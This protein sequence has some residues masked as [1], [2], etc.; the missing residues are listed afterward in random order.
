[1]KV[2]KTE[3][4]SDF[5]DKEKRREYYSKIKEP[6]SSLSEVD[7]YRLRIV[8]KYLIGKSVL[9]IGTYR[10]D[11]LKM[12]S[13]KFEITGLDFNNECVNIV[14]DYF[15]KKVAYVGNLEI[16]DHLIFKDN[17]FD[18]VTCLEVIEHLP[19]IG[20]VINE[21]E[22]IARKRIIISV[23][24]KEIIGY[25]HCIHCG[26]KTPLSGHLHFFDENSLNQ[27][28]KQNEKVR[29]FLISNSY[30][31]FFRLYKFPLFISRFLDHFLNYFFS[32]N[33]RW[34]TYIIDLN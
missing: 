8:E 34:I 24:Y 3:N 17:S 32:D 21:L 7:F 20:K 25:T 19:D 31:S 18:T 33:A 27:Y 11:F 28:L 16:D 4:L 9:D 2:H 22:R 23:P 1:M 10:G 12:I 30:F 15:K 14:N 29:C 6:L 13:D 5:T 26:N